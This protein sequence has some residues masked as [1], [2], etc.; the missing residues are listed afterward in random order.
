[1]VHGGLQL[2]LCGSSDMGPDSN[3]PCSRQKVAFTVAP[4]QALKSGIASTEQRRKRTL[5][6]ISTVSAR[7]PTA[8]C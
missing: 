4:Q 6:D 8:R 5:I 7:Q 1:L 2:P 3:N